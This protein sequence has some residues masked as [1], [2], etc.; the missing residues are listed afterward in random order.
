MATIPK[1]LYARIERRLCQDGEAA[2][3]QAREALA[4]ARAQAYAIASPQGGT[5]HGGGHGD[6]VQASAM[7]IIAAERALDTELRWN[8]LRTRLADLLPTARTAQTAQ[9]IYRKRMSSAETA[10]RLG[11]DRQT[12][13]RDRD[14]AVFRASVLAAEMGLIRAE[15]MRE[16]DAGCRR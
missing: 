1:A 7:R 2:I 4:D 3:R 8:D 16:E 11:V 15:E 13:R 10:R 14:D 12:I 6:P 5:A 9:M